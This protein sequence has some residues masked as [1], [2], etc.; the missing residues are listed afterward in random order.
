C[1]PI[2]FRCGK[3]ARIGGARS[4]VAPNFTAALDERDYKRLQ[5]PVRPGLVNEKRLGCAADSGAPELGVQ[6]DRAGFLEVS[7]FVRVHM[8]D[9][10]KMC[11]DWNASLFL[12]AFDEAFS[13]TRNDDVDGAAKPLKEIADR[14]AIR[15]RDELNGCLGQLRS[16]QTLDEASVNCAIAFEAFGAAAKD[17]GI[18]GFEA[19]PARVGCDIGTAFV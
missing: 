18:A 13:P 11:K 4:G 5:K 7:G 10:F 16:L 15:C 8:A 19:E 1:G 12:Y 2:R 3:D 17:H 9:A 14:P 6:D